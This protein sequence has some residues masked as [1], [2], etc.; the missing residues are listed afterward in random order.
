VVDEAEHG[1]ALGEV[2]AIGAGSYMERL[3]LQLERF[4]DT[5]KRLAELQQIATPGVFDAEVLAVPR[6]KPVTGRRKRDGG[7]N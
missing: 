3:G 1:T 4:G 5:D 6:C 7:K 2:A